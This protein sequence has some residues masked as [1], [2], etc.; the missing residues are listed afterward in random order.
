MVN[1]FWAK[2]FADIKR[3]ASKIVALS[4]CL[5]NMFRLNL[6]SLWYYVL[7]LKNTCIV[8]LFEKRN[9]TNS[10]FVVG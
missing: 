7:K 8:I 9:D 1:F 3:T 2:R 6:K 5:E 4:I 10:S